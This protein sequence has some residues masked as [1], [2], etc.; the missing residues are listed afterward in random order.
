MKKKISF[1]L[2]LAFVMACISPLTAFAVNETTGS[3][4]VSLD[5]P[6][7]TNTGGGDTTDSGQSYSYIVDIPASFSITNG[8]NSFQITA[9]SMDIPA[10]KE[11]VVRINGSETFESDG[12]FYLFLNG[13][14]TSEHWIL[15]NIFRIQGNI[16]SYV[17][18]TNPVIASFSP[19]GLLPNNCD[20]IRIEHV[21]YYDGA[22]LAAGTYTGTIYYTI[23]LE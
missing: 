12:S 7:T 10:D 23:G 6:L 20:S 3:T 17:I 9:N 14:K 16:T 2:S 15:C 13:D 22:G 1:L 8:S 21:L 19:G 5:F 4:D 11:L 18:G